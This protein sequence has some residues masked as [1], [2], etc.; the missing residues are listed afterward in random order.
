MDATQWHEV[1][2]GEHPLENRREI[3]RRS[4]LV[5][6]DFRGEQGQ[7]EGPESDQ[8]R[9]E[10]T[11]PLNPSDTLKEEDMHLKKILSFAVAALFACRWERA[12]ARKPREQALKAAEDALN[13]GK[14]MP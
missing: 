9:P 14:P 12:R 4:G 6:H 5:H 8:D 11:D 2:K 10:V 1:K 3:L 7:A 13:A